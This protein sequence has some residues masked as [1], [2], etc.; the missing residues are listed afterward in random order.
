VI[1]LY[2][3]Y[4]SSTSHLTVFVFPGLYY[5]S[6]NTVDHSILRFTVATKAS[7]VARSLKLSNEVMS[8][9]QER[10][11]AVNLCPFVGVDLM[12]PT[13]YRADTWGRNMNQTQTLNA[14][15]LHL[16]LSLLQLLL[17]NSIKPRT[18]IESVESR[19]SSSFQLLSFN[20]F[21]VFLKVPGLPFILYTTPLSHINYH[22]ATNIQLLNGVPQ[23]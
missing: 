12:W 10:P 16:D 14:S 18:S 23:G 3:S 11:S 22:V 19:N 7:S 21:M 6:L 2:K 5:V 1:I 8:D 20:F 9:R 4:A 13:V 17:R 15:H